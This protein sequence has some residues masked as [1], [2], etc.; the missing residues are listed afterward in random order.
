VGLREGPML[1]AVNYYAGTYRGVRYVN[2]QDEDEAVRKVTAWV[3][4]E[5]MLPMYSFRAWVERES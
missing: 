4:R 1:Y 5:M 2:A 3:R